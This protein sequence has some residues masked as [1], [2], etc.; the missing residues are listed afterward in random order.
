M[1]LIKKNITANFIGTF[2]MALMSLAFVPLY[3]KFLGIESWGIIG[4]FTALRSVMVIFD[5]GLSAAMTRE[6]SRLSILPGKEQEMRNL[7]KSM[8]IVYWGI[9]VFIGI[10]GKLF[11]MT[12]L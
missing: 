1:S 7:V 4:I 10:A 8:E 11:K 5:L 9:A 12:R 2:W 3:I 6:L